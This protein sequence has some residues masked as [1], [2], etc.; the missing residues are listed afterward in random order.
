MQGIT[1]PTVE[2]T[3][4]S[5]LVRK[6]DPARS[7]EEL[8]DEVFGYT[9]LLD[10]DRLEKAF[11]QLGVKIPKASKPLFDNLES[12][13]KAVGVIKRCNDFFLIDT[14]RNGVPVKEALKIVEKAFSKIIKSM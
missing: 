12:F 13:E 7:V 6:E 2:G 8:A 10:G 11:E 9:D 5:V 3:I 4:F 14:K 1:T